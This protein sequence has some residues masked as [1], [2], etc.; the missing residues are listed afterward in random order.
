MMCWIWTVLFVSLSFGITLCALPGSTYVNCHSGTNTLMGRIDE[1]Y[2]GTIDVM[3]GNPENDTILLE[4]YRYPSHLEF[5]ELNITGNATLGV[6]QTRKPLDAEALKDSKG[7]LYFLISC[8]NSGR[9]NIRVIMVSNI[10]DNPPVFEKDE[11]RVNISE[12]LPVGSLVLTLKAV[13]AD[14]APTNSKVIYA[15]L[16]P[17]P[18]A[19]E[20]REDGSM[21]LME[22]L[23]YNNISSHKFTV[24]AR[25]EGGL[26]SRSNVIINVQD[27]DN[28][29]PYFEHNLY[30][31]T[32]QENWV[33]AVPRVHPEPVRALDGDTGINETLIYSISS[34]S[35]SKYQSNFV[36]APHTG[37]ITVMS[38]LNREEISS[39]LLG[40]KAS[41][42]DDSQK[43]A[44]STFLV[45]IDD[46]PEA[47]VFS[48]DVYSAQI[49]NI[50]PYKFPVVKVKATDP[51]AGE[52]E[53]LQYSLVEP[54]NL[55]AVDPSSG[56]VYVVSAGGE[57][58]KITL[59]VKAEDKLG[60]HDITTVEVTLI[61]SGSSNVAVLSL[62][63]A[64]KTVEDSAAQVEE[65][66]GRVLGWT[67]RIMSVTNDAA[68]FQR[69]VH[70]K[71][72]VTFI[73]MEP[74]GTAV[75]SQEE[76]KQRLQSE[77]ESVRMELGKVFGPGL[78]VGVEEGL[79]GTNL[80]PDNQATVVTL[81]VFLAVFMA[82]VP[83]S[84]LLT[85]RLSKGNRNERPSLTSEPDDMLTR[86]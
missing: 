43:T 42:Q 6:I 4:P 45:H 44:G 37:V 22:A 64:V 60:L 18:S 76:V 52:T 59:Q 23:D 5:L 10:N 61:D 70:P 8:A 2:A 32:V 33:G 86:F 35:P 39:I 16:P 51:D 41:Q 14:V 19:F 9:K 84:V 80:R 78:Q 26:S 73:A 34:V 65:S 38:P 7:N 28:L 15:T 17:V 31:T 21:F 12:T 75:L 69:E 50:A 72:Y 57:S 54:S 81:G 3:R 25:D 77:E 48:S 85:R 67:V 56:Q 27:Y 46:A 74:G 53:V 62:N 83:V 11:Y 20:L 82:L 55:F 29:N 30:E 68:L 49:F 63:M 58:G 1:G 66:L 79:T 47:P 24:E 40:I 71:T 13:D 36:I